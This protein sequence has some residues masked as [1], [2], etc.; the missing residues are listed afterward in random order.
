[1]WKG[2]FESD[3]GDRDRDQH[4]L[5]QQ[6]FLV[7]KASREHVSLWSEGDLFT[8]WILTAICVSLSLLVLLSALQPAKPLPSWSLDGITIFSVVV[9]VILSFVRNDFAVAA[10]TRF[11]FVKLYYYGMVMRVARTC[12]LALLLLSSSA[13]VFP[14]LFL[15]VFPSLRQPTVA[16]LFVGSLVGYLVTYPIVAYTNFFS[17]EG[18]ASM[19]LRHALDYDDPSDFN[20]WFRRGVKAAIRRLEE[21]GVRVVGPDIIFAV[22]IKILRGEPVKDMVER[23]ASDIVNLPKP[24]NELSEMQPFRL[25]DTI[26]A[27]TEL[28]QAARKDGLEAVPSIR[29]RASRAWDFVGKSVQIIA[30]ILALS[31]A[32]YAYLMSGKLPF[33]SG[34]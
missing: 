16:Y 20:S 18:E 13:F 29:E 17:Y 8:F 28:A 9:P 5:L 4:G 6:G 11:D 30:F 7:M 3:L 12:I 15:L 26:K 21:I 23:I 34:V 14:S 31:I 33:L 25:Y 27:L 1:M 10:A 19:C 2:K 24:K 22:N 32:L